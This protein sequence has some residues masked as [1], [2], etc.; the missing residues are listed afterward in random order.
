[1]LNGGDMWIANSV[2]ACDT[3]AVGMWPSGKAIGFGP[4]IPG[5]NPGIPAFFYRRSDRTP[6]IAS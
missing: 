1:M 3:T 4:M 5:S 2:A 6:E